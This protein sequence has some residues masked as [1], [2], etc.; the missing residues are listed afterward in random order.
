MSEKYEALR[1]ALDA[2]APCGSFHKSKSAVQ[3]D[4]TEDWPNIRVDVLANKLVAPVVAR[5][6]TEAEPGTIRALLA[7]HDRLQAQVEQLR[8]EAKVASDRIQE[9][10]RFTKAQRGEIE[11]LR[12]D[13]ERLDWLTEQ[14]VDTIYLDD[15]H[16]IDVGTGRIGSR[17]VCVSPHD[18]R[19]AIDSA[20]AGREDG[21]GR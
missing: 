15:G 2:M 1:K 20:R 11:G 19:A 16:I 4:E 6:I 5:Y 8:T 13:A 21:N 10:G 7:D 12:A 17:D 3:I 9:L 14:L 18:L